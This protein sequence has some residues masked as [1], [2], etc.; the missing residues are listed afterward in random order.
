MFNVP[1]QETNVP[2]NAP[3]HTFSEYLKGNL[4]RTDQQ[5]ITQ[6]P[7]LQSKKIAIT[8]FFYE[9]EIKALVKVTGRTHAKVVA[10]NDNLGG[11]P[12]FNWIEDEDEAVESTGYKPAKII[13]FQIITSEQDV[14]EKTSFYTGFTYDPKEGESFTVPFGEATTAEKQGGVRQSIVEGLEGDA[15]KQYIYTFK[16]EMV[17]RG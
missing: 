15:D 3:I 5:A 11:R 13:I 16:P 12:R 6:P 2:D 9:P 17:T 4:E 1:N 10:A 14:Q 8:P 7:R